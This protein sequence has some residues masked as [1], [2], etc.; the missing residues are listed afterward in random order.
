[1][2]VER[3]LIDATDIEA[4]AY[5]DVAAASICDWLHARQLIDT[6]DEYLGVT[7]PNKMIRQQLQVADAKPRIA[8]R[9]RYLTEGRWAASVVESYAATSQPVCRRYSTLVNLPVE[10]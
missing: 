6:V 5:P 7:V 3:W 9:R 2:S 8:M 1:M 10:D 4:A